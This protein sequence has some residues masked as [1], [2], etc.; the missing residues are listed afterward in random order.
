[1]MAVS[2]DLPA[3]LEAELRSQF[4]NLDDLA[5][6]ALGI[7]L[8]RRGR[9]TQHQLGRLLSRN[10]FDIDALLQKHGVF[11]DLTAEDVR[12]EAMSLKS[13]RESC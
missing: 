12:D 10:R 4:T 8:Y 1:M 3:D 2:F 7:D 11:Y 13:A 5:R 6:E 9:I